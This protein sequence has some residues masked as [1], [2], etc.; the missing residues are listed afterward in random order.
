[1]TADIDTTGVIATLGLA[2]AREAPRLTHRPDLIRQQLHN[3]LQWESGPIPGIL[4]REAARAPQSRPWLRLRNPIP[5][6]TAFRQSLIGH[7]LPVVA[8]HIDPSGAMIA[9][10]GEDAHLIVWEAR[11]GRELARWKAASSFLMGCR[12]VAGDRIL[13]V[14]GDGTVS[15]WSL[16][17]TPRGSLEGHSGAVVGCEVAPGG[18]R[19]VTASDDGSAIVWDLDTT[20]II[21]ILKAP[22]LPPAACAFAPDGRRVATAGFDGSVRLW[23]AATGA[24]VGVLRGHV[25]PVAGCA[26]GP[27]GLLVSA[28]TDGTVRMWGP[29]GEPGAVASGHEG[30]VLTCAVVGDG[31]MIVSGGD[32]RLI[33]LWDS[34]TGEPITALHGHSD[35]IYDCAVSPDGS[36][37]VSGS[38]DLTARVWSTAGIRGDVVQR[39]GHREGVTGCAV[40]ARSETAVSTGDDGELRFWSLGSLDP[41]GTITTDTPL[42]SC[43]VSADGRRVAAGGA[44]QAIRVW[45]LATSELVGEYD[46]RV[47]HRQTLSIRGC[48]LDSEGMRVAVMVESIVRVLDCATGE[49]IRR[50][51]R[52]R[53]VSETVRTHIAATSL[54][55]LPDGELLVAYRD[56]SLI[57]W[58]LADGTARTIGEH[59]ESLEGCAAAGGLMAS[60]DESGRVCVWDPAEGEAILDRP[61]HRGRA[62]VCALSGDGTLVAS[63]GSDR[64]VAV[65]D[66]ASGDRIATLPAE[67]WVTALAFDGT[68]R[69]LLVGDEGGALY[70]ADLVGLTPES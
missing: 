23:D 9:T 42:R 35:G 43:A 66:V 41:A 25:G 45:D 33:R 8:T 53:E 1:M 15:L 22:P 65:H 37:I 28:G 30:R 34:A 67:G 11:S 69:M 21:S 59:D 44:D 3:R 17:G 2:I 62:G 38:R 19:A 50:L 14:A 52:F 60:C 12:F 70:A 57:T 47:D 55:F 54:V 24:A 61:V 13:T 68:G 46:D 36:F 63:G 20:Q 29:D 48:S 26:F 56:G 39:P 4:R 16:D 49:E 31:G 51:E 7:R 32:D 27:D 5:E 64:M 58:T 10:A 6:A 40:V 18:G